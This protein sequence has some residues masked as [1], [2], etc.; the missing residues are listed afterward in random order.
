MLGYSSERGILEEGESN[1]SEDT[2]EPVAIPVRKSW[3]KGGPVV[4]ELKVTNERELADAYRTVMRLV[5]E[6]AIDW[7]AASAVNSSLRY[8]SKLLPPEQS[9][10][11]QQSRVDFQEFLDQNPEAQAAYVEYLKRKRAVEVK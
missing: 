1:L 3:R 8:L 4:A 10:Q 5:L 11:S 6:G 9:E 2:V 7:K